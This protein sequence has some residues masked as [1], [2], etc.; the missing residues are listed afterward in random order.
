MTVS[1]NR[2]AARGDVH[3]TFPDANRERLP[4]DDVDLQDVDP[5]R[6]SPGK[7]FRQDM[8]L[9]ERLEPLNGLTFKK[10]ASLTVKNLGA[11]MTLD[12]PFMP[13]QLFSHWMSLLQFVVVPHMGATP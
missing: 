8:F 10:C 2:L 6:P 5:V 3:R 4:F 1:V 13:F 9:H 12:S 7:L 11:V